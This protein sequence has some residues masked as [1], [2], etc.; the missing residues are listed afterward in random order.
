[1]S[2]AVP[3]IFKHNYVVPETKPRN[4][5]AAEKRTSKMVNISV[6][7]VSQTRS[8]LTATDRLSHRRSAVMPRR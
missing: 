7:R 2:M 1:M 8:A 3:S 5:K 6:R 4:L